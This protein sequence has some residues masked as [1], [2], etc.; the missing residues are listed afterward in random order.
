[1]LGLRQQRKIDIES[2]SK[3]KIEL[4]KALKADLLY[5]VGETTSKVPVSFNFV[6]L[7]LPTFTSIVNSGQ[8]LLLDPV[9]IRLLRELNTE[10]HEHNIAQAIFVGVEG[11]QN[12]TEMSSN[13][14][15]L[16]SLL[17]N[18]RSESKSR[19]G[20]LLKVIMKERKTIAEIAEELIQHLSKS[21]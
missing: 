20:G 10:M 9:T 1:L 2:D 19:L 14:D 11:S 5:L 7:D 6:F 12:P 16:K 8:L 17:E 21:K 18:P 4:V 3:R 13:S 15:E